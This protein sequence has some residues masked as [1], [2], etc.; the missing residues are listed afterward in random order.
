MNRSALTL[1]EVLLAL[2][3][4][5]AATAAGASLMQTSRSAAGGSAQRFDAA[6]V[7]RR[8][9]ADTSRAAADA[10]PVQAFEP[11]AWTDPKG[12]TWSVVE[13]PAPGPA[14]AP[15]TA[16]VPNRG[17]DEHL[18]T[19]DW[20]SIELYCAPSPGAGSELVLRALVPAHAEHDA[21]GAP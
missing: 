15:G 16:T 21:R 14:P 7:L 2:A 19:I 12:R 5:T 13:T 10:E 4:L 9:Q 11:W 8:W 6:G 17:E 20:V 18:P 3:L 1:L